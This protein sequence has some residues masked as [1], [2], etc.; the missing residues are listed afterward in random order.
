MVPSQVGAAPAVSWKQQKETGEGLAPSKCA[1]PEVIIFVYY[2]F[3]YD[4]GKKWGATSLSQNA[5]ILVLRRSS[6]THRSDCCSASP[7][8][9]K[10]ERSFWK[11]G[12]KFCELELGLT[13][14]WIHLSPVATVFFLVPHLLFL[15]L[16]KLKIG[17]FWTQCSIFKTT[18][19]WPCL[20]REGGGKTST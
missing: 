19:N 9:L 16:D 11:R 14:R 1:L 3:W 18:E 20:P 8:G 7:Y 12:F 10:G 15:L 17:L 2:P 13:L 4:L 5:A 6:S